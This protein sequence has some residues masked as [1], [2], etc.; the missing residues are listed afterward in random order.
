MA[1]LWNY[2]HASYTPQSKWGQYISLPICSN[3]TS[4]KAFF[5]LS[6][7][8]DML[9]F[10]LFP[11][12]SWFLLCFRKSQRVVL[13]FYLSSDALFTAHKQRH[14]LPPVLNS[15]TLFLT[16]W[17]QCPQKD[18][19]LFKIVLLMGA[20]DW[21]KAGISFSSS[22]HSP[23]LLEGAIVFNQQSAR[24]RT[25]KRHC[26]C[27]TRS[28]WGYTAYPHSSMFWVKS[29]AIVLC[30]NSKKTHHQCWK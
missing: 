26:L 30:S 13:G 20:M 17:Q 23:T 4:Q 12:H 24:M 27:E 19:P 10:L 16:S 14:P 21:A 22:S 9:E 11:L 25:G 5:G 3:T 29:K 15:A 18:V 2:F 28:E 6:W 1:N 7:L 8:S